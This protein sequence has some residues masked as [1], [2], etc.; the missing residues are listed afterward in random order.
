MG[1]GGILQQDENHKNQYRESIWNMVGVLSKEPDC[2]RRIEMLLDAALE[3]FGADRAY[4]IEGDTELVTA[5]NTHERCAPGIAFQQ[6]T[7]KDMPVEA[8]MR[9]LGVFQRNE[10]VVIEDMED[11][12]E[13]N[14]GEYQ[15]FADS[16][17]HAII[18][19]PF[20]KRINH[21]FVGVDN[22][23]HNRTDATT[24]RILA[25][26]IALE[27]NEI[28][29]TQEKAALLDVSKYPENIVH[30][31][32]L[33][34][35]KISARG[36]TIYQNSF[37]IQGQAILAIM[38]LNPEKQ[39]SIEDLYDII[40]P[41]KEADNPG[42]VVSNVVY[43]VRSRL[44]I[45]GLKELVHNERGAYYLNPRFQV[46]TDVSRFKQFASAMQA[47][48]SDEDKL[49][50]GEEALSL[51]INPLP[52]AICNHIRLVIENSELERLFLGIC[53]ECADIYMKRRKYGKAMDIL[54]LALRNNPLETDLILLRVQL[55]KKSGASGLKSYVRRI[56]GAL[57]KD[58]LEQLYRIMDGKE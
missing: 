14:P 47:A 48:E 25:Y 1:D 12:R 17:V 50:L 34:D 20:T 39:F 6:D 24:L 16:D 22:P 55:M 57:D 42:S 37:T 18:V 21:G 49:Q 58:E 40:S 46:E 19:V 45:I 30:V 38:L 41:S 7:L 3:F 51:Y 23:T 43:K 35:M 10:A 36:G 52:A 53:K 15:Y 2:T 9:W 44:D 27:L 13:S 26:A 11:M 32:L 8:Y 33:G 56:E 28:K 5:V 29:L 4:V 31:H 54:L